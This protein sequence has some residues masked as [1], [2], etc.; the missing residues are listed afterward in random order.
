V[1]PF[2]GDRAT[3]DDVVELLAGIGRVLQSVD[4][5][6]EETNEYLRGDDDEGYRTDV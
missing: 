1:W 5:R 3:L 4:A 2:L 6:I